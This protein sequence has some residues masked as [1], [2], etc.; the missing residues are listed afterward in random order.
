MPTQFSHF[1]D[2]YFNRLDN[3]E[4]LMIDHIDALSE[5][6][7]DMKSEIIKTFETEREESRKQFVLMRERI[8]TSV[9]PLSLGSVTASEELST[10]KS[11]GID[12]VEALKRR[13]K[14]LEN[15]IENTPEKEKSPSSTRWQ[16]ATVVESIRETITEAQSPRKRVQSNVLTREK[17]KSPNKE[18]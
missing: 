6:L 10:G 16:G 7:Q 12:E 13:I 1:Q 2:Y 9:P 14:H 18:Q 17:I 4:K 8:N 15:L 11:A 5:R 3:Q